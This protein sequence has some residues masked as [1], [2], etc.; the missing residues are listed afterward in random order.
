MIYLAL[1]SCFWMFSTILWV[2]WGDIRSNM[3]SVSGNEAH[4]PHFWKGRFWTHD[5]KRWSSVGLGDWQQ[6]LPCPHG[7]SWFLLD[8]FNLWVYDGLCLI[9]EVLSFAK[10]TGETHTHTSHLGIHHAKIWHTCWE[11]GH[12]ELSTTKRCE[13]Q[14]TMA[15]THKSFETIIFGF[16]FILNAG[17]KRW[18][19]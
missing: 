12:P 18:Q 6:Q 2:E 15:L 10:R 1:Q 17:I 3:I 8:R 9:Q 19:F 14:S 4:I 13:L 11:D 5:S 7:K 16:M